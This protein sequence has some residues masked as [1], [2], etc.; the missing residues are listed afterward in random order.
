M[1]GGLSLAKNAG[2]T[3]QKPAKTRLLG[4]GNAAQ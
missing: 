2:T 1:T 4:V 3:Q